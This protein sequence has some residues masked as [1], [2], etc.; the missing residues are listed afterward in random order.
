MDLP[1]YEDVL[2]AADRLRGQAVETPLLESPLL[3]ARLGGRLLLKTE[4]LQHTGA[5]KFRGAYARLSLLTGEEKRRG[6][7]AH[8][9]GNHAQGVAYAASRLGIAS[10]VVIPRDAPQI[11]ID[12]NKAYGA[13]VV[14]Y[15]RQTE[16]RAAIAADIAKAR[17]AVVVPPYDDPAVIA[18]QGTMAIEIRSQAAAVDARLDA[19]IVPC[20][21]GGMTAGC[22]LV[23]AAESPD[24]E[25]YTVEP[26]GF[27]DTARSLAA[28]KRLEN[29]PGQH[30]FCDA[31]LA[32]TPGEITFAVNRTRLAGALKVTDRDVAEAM[33][34]AFLHFKVVMEPSGAVALAAVLAGKFDCRDKTVAIVASGG[35]IDL[36]DFI[37]A[38]QSARN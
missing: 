17:G 8:S 13:E 23:M 15:E 29:Q 31:L 3:N 19:L 16:D 33:L 11:K 36:D 35:N 5:F 28:G 21:G 24:T 10:T 18:G 25:I 22:A 9:A 38:L 26:E 37:A 6:V 32:P 34:A 12:N 1:T 2:A 7:V 14:L 30:S 27:D 20:G 4:I